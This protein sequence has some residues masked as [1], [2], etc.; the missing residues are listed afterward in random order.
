MLIKSKNEYK[1]YNNFLKINLNNFN[2][3]D[4]KYLQFFHYLNDKPTL[5]NN[6]KIID[7]S[8]IK[9]DLKLFFQDNLK[10]DLILLFVGVGSFQIDRYLITLINHLSKNYSILAL[11][12]KDNPEY[13]HLLG[14]YQYLL[15]IDKLK[16]FKKFKQIFIIAYSGGCG[17]LYH[18]IKNKLWLDKIKGAFCISI[19]L[20]PYWI[21]S[22]VFARFKFYNSL[23]KKLQIHQKFNRNFYGDVSLM[24]NFLLEHYHQ[25]NFQQ[26]IDNYK[27]FWNQS[28][29]PFPLIILLSNDDDF[30]QLNQNDLKYIKNNIMLIH[31]LKGYHCCFYKNGYL[32]YL[33]LIDYLLNTYI[34]I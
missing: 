24:Y 29:V 6:I 14:N 13:F 31:T 22:G 28:N 3:L 11:S 7:Y 34:K 17:N 5:D 21:N 2:N 33:P 26:I 4:S 15:E 10:D 23:E 32:S 9:Y 27:S 20:I 18:I 16:I 19:I 1:I 8:T 25:S 30:F 12:Q